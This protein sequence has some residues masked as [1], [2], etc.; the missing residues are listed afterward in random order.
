[1]FAVPSFCLSTNARKTERGAN[2]FPTSPAVRASPFALLSD[3]RKTERGASMFLLRLAMRAA[4]C[5]LLSGILWAQ[6]Q[7]G[8]APSPTPLASAPVD[9][10]GYWVSVITEDWRFRMVTPPKGDFASVPLNA[11]GVR[12]A[13]EWDPAK[14]IAAGEQCRVFS[15]AGIMRMPVRL[16]V[17]W[18]GES[19]LKVEIDNGNQVRLF[20][21]DRSSPP[22]SQADR[23]GFS[24]A[25][26]ENVQEGQ[27]LAPAGG[28]RGGAVGFGASVPSGQPLSSSLKVVTTKMRPGY[29]RR[30]GVPY[31]GNAVMTEFFDRTDEANGDSWLILTSVL[32]DPQYLQQ[33][34]MLT[35]HYKREADGAK[36]NPRPCEVTPPVVGKRS[37]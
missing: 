20:R 36:F 24:L 30:N 15:A 27:G 22:P 25:E 16:H 8:P 37:Q 1:M 34:F 23:Q 9:L 4:P 17:T 29:L 28:G 19:T 7:G 32:D 31:S 35:T 21:F 12:V 10:T 2:P 13:K 5:V 3:T 26:W 18:Q 11:E 33:P 6:G 14:D